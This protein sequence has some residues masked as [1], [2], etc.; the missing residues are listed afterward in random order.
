MD[1][2]NATVPGGEVDAPVT[3]ME[4]EATA[5]ET[6]GQDVEQPETDMETPE[7]ENV[8]GEEGAEDPDAE[9]EYDLGGGQKVKFKANATAKEVAETAQR[10][11]KEVEANWTRKNQEIAET[12]KS[13]EAQ[14][15][16]VEKLATVNGEV[17][18]IYSRGQGVKAELEQLQRID[19][20]Q[21]WQSNPDQARQVSDRLAAKQAEFQ[22]IVSTL[23]AKESEAAQ[24]TQ[25][26][27]TRRAGEGR[28]MLQR[29]IKDFDKEL[30]DI[31]EYAVN[32]L[33]IPKDAAEK[34]YA[35]NPAMTLAVRKAMLFDRM[36]AANKKP[37]PK[38]VQAAPVT[39]MKAQGNAKPVKSVKAMTPGEM[40]R[41]LGLPG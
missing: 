4:T 37:T 17:L 29:Q 12:R 14:E 21:L 25:V 36:Q 22:T 11:F 16:A 1:P 31:I 41:H 38:P 24:E 30:P 23:N 7:G 3:D 26:E 33:G 10:A 28:S 13:V 34:D 40:A 2:E 9:V 6:E 8:D 20:N 19:L 18:N 39:A 15:R 35:L 32:S 5:T 27:M